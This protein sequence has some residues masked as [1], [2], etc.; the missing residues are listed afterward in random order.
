[1]DVEVNGIENRGRQMV[2]SSFNSGIGFLLA[3][4][5]ESKPESV[6]FQGL[7]FKMQPN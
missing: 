2:R 4:S 7:G 5:D 6:L 3:R 1:M